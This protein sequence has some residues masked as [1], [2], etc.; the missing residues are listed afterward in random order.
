MATS[1]PW[2]KAEAALKLAPGINYYSTSSHGGYKV[3]AKKYGQIPPPLR[4]LS[5][6][7][8]WFEDKE[9]WVA[10][11]LSFPQYFDPDKVKE[12]RKLVKRKYPSTFAKL[13]I[14]E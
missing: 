9:A 1:T 8:E 7:K 3:S 11:A 13:A 14:T 2:G 10:V 6:G 12:A 4:K 5:K